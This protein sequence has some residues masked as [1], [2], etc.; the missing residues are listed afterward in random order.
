MSFL[1]PLLEVQDL[2]IAAD[3]ART[4]SANLPERESLPMLVEKLAQSDAGLT[5]ARAEREARETEE[6]RL[7]REVAKIAH[8]IEA[9]D[10]ERYSGK[11]KNQEKGSAHKATQTERHDKQATL[12]ERELE[13][14]EEIEAVERRITEDEAA[15]A[16]QH[17]LWEKATLAI[18]LVDA[19][20]D[21][22]I[23]NLSERRQKIALQI[24][25]PLL[26]AYERVR[27]QPQTAGRGAAML[28]EGRCRG[29]G[30]NLPSLVKTRMMAEPEDA[31]IQCPQCRRVLVR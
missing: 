21:R 30:I 25:K 12:E 19:D 22:E 9:A 7:G 11:R 27:T 6:E 26:V 14:L 31:L 2:D 8:E 23:A 13:L 10:V 18:R 28:V 15:R 17:D 20:V 29:C 1:A 24:P 16:G 5:A 4:R 3:A